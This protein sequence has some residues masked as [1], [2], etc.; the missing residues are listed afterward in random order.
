MWMYYDSFS[1]STRNKTKY[2]WLI[3]LT[4]NHSDIVAD[5]V[6]DLEAAWRP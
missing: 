4:G 1:T 5:G 3:N 6:F 2:D